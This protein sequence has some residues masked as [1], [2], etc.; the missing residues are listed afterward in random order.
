MWKEGDTQETSKDENVDEAK[1]PS[2]ARAMIKRKRLM[3]I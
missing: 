3:A 1:N 2:K